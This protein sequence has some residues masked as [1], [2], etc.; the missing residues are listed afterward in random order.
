MRI[1]GS[2]PADQDRFGAPGSKRLPGVERSPAATAG[3]AI[4]PDRITRDTISFGVIAGGAILIDPI[5]RLVQGIG[6]VVSMKGSPQ[7]HEQE[8]AGQQ[9]ARNRS[10]GEA[11]HGGDRN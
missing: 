3:K 8:V 1:G 5:A 2:G 9:E 4:W 7:R 10:V 6:F 11:F